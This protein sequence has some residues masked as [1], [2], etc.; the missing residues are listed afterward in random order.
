MT[1]TIG[2]LVLSAMLPLSA[3]AWKHTEHA[4]LPEDM[5]LKYWV[6]DDGTVDTTCEETV[7][8]GYCVTS[9]EQGYAAW[10]AAPCADYTDSYEGLCENIEHTA[11]DRQNFMTYNDPSILDPET[12]EQ[13]PEPGTL[14]VTFTSSSGVAFRLDGTPYRHA[15]D[16]DIVFNDNVQFD[17]HESIAGGSCNGGTNMRSVATHEIGHLLGMGHSCEREESC[18]DAKLRGAVMYWSAGPCGTQ[19][20]IAE[21]DIEGIT[22]LYGPSARFQCSHETGEGRVVAS[23]PFTMK[24]IVVSDFID[25]VVSAEWSFGDGGQSSD[26]NPKHQ[27]T[28][29][30]NYTVQVTVNGEREECGPD[31]WQ[32]NFRRVGYV[33]ACDIPEVAFSYEHVNGLDYQMLNETNVSVYGCIQGIQWDVFRGTDTTGEPVLSLPAWEPIIEFPD[34]DTY[35]IVAN[36]GGYAGTGAAMLT[37][38]A[39]NRPGEGRGCSTTGLAGGSAS[40]LLLALGALGLRRRS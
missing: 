37:L 35:T 11:E 32:N 26:I 21:D 20:E 8:P 4:W 10:H 14:A 40:L 24:C 3:H 15:T 13:I 9:A 16:S 29:A 28:A 23:V 12:L 5:P 17:T 31:G 38:D 2:A 36:V 6:A 25:E 27:Y 19:S 22:T 30:G 39:K 34:E 18:K 33:R 7:P 1:R